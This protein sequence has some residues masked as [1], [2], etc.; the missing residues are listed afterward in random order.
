MEIPPLQQLFAPVQVALQKNVNWTAEMYFVHFN[1]R[2]KFALLSILNWKRNWEITS[3]SWRFL[4]TVIPKSDQEQ[5][6]SQRWQEN[7]RPSAEELSDISMPRGEN[8]TPCNPSLEI[9]A[10]LQLSLAIKVSCERQR[11]LCV[12]HWRQQESTT[13]TF[14]TI[15]LVKD[16]KKQQQA[17]TFKI[18]HTVHLFQKGKVNTNITWKYSLYCFKSVRL[19]RISVKLYEKCNKK[20]SVSY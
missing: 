18:C 12:A 20:L 14:R 8:L 2:W 4:T 3:L 13:C 15:L 6:S 10:P 19:E 1:K 11:G 16:C 17:N 9:S 7:R 5:S